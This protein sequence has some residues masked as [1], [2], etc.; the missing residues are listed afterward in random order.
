MAQTTLLNQKATPTKVAIILP[1]YNEEEVL[2]YSSKKLLEL[3]N[4][5]IE[6]KVIDRSS[7]LFFIDDG[8]KDKTWDIIADL[9]HKHE[10]I[11]G[12]KL[13][14][15]FGHQN[16]VLAG[17]QIGHQEADCTI[18]IDVDLQ[19]DINVIKD[20]ILAYQA[21][22][23]IV[24]GVRNERATDTFFKKNTALLFYKLIKG[25]GVEI[26]YNHADFRLASK[27]VIEKLFNFDEVNLFLRGMFPLIGFKTTSVFYNRLERTAGE[28]K[29]PFKKMLAFAWE[30]ITSFSIKPLRLVTRLGMLVFLISIL[31]A[32]YSL[33]SFFFKDT[34]PGWTSITLPIYFISGIQLLSMGVLGEYIGK[35]YKE[36]KKRPRFIIEEVI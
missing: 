16:A 17:L 33:Y 26:V 18:S 13:S 4:R 10:N 23:Q 29:Y 19:D 31:L 5:L 14:R 32:F 6:E 22:N 7:F 20:M 9:S 21:G 27:N 12:L 15:N 28:S 25:L 8:S 30:G 35:I 1:C 24:Y 34:V 36:T 3:L 11:K 2:N